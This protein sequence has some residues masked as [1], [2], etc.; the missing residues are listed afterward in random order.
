M[1]CPYKQLPKGVVRH[2]PCSWWFHGRHYLK[3]CG[4]WFMHLVGGDVVVDGVRLGSED[5]STFHYADQLLGLH[6]VSVFQQVSHTLSPKKSWF[7]GKPTPNER[8]LREKRETIFHWTMIMGGRVWLNVTIA[9]SCLVLGIFPKPIRKKQVE[10]CWTD[11]I[12]CIY[13]YMKF[14]SMAMDHWIH[15]ISQH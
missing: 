5:G 13:I 3:P 1:I 4:H 14:W 11:I 15:G 7:S 8:K 6:R 9:V 12:C 10:E 2:L